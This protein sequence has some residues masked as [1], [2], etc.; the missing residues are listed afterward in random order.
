MLGWGMGRSDGNLVMDTESTIWRSTWKVVG[1]VTSSRLEDDMFLLFNGMIVGW[2]WWTGVGL[3]EYEVGMDDE[4]NF[5][6]ECPSCHMYK[7]SV[8]IGMELSVFVST[9]LT[10]LLF[11]YEGCPPKSVPSAVSGAE[12]TD[13]LPGLPA[14]FDVLE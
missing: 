1:G 4:G 13:L 5:G 14:N 9:H 2:K 12:N 7:S 8:S 10:V 11:V 6:D 3:A